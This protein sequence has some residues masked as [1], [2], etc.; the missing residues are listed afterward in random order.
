MKFKIITLL[1]LLSFGFIENLK[2]QTFVHPGLPFTTGD[3]DRM[4]ANRTASPWQESWEL[5]LNSDQASLDYVMQGPTID[6]ENGGNDD[7][8][9]NDVNAI[10]YHALQYYFTKDEAYAEKAIAI[11]KP[12]VRTHKTWSG[13]SAH[14]SAAWRGGTFAQACEILRYTYP[15]WTDELSVE[16]ED[17]LKDVFWPLFRLPDPL[18]SANQGANNLMGAMYVA[19]F[20]NDKEKFDMCIEAFLN[21]SCGGISN[22]LPNG[23]NGD[24]GRDQG[25]AMAMIGNLATV[26]EIAWA[27][28]FDLYSALDNRLLTIHEYWTKYNLGNDVPWIDFGTCYGYYTSIGADGRTAS[29][30][31]PIPVTEMI[32][33][34]YVIRKGLSA[35]YVTE[36]RAGLPVDENTFLYRKDN[37]FLSTNP[38]FSYDSD[39]ELEYSDV[40][41]LTA[42]DIGTVG[43]A[44]SS[45][46][47]NG[48]WTVAGSGLN[49]YGSS[50]NDSFHYAYK[51]MSGDG[52]FIAKITSMEVSNS[53][54]KAALVIKETLDSNSKMGEVNGTS[55]SSSE[56]S[57]R[58]SDSADGSGKQSFEL[59]TVPTWVKIERIGDH[60][61]GYV[62]P[63]GVSWAPMQY[64]KYTMSDDFYIGL[65]VTSNSNSLTCTSTFT[66][67]Q[68][69]ATNTD[70]EIITTAYTK[71]E[72]E[73]YTSMSGITT[74]TT[75]DT[76]GDM[77][78]ST[79]NT[80]DWMEYTIN[81]PYSGTYSMDYRIASASDGNFTVSTTD[82]TLE[83]V[84]FTATGGN[85]S[86]ATVPS[87]S[88]FYLSQGVQ[89]I[90]IATNSSDWKI[91]WLR[92]F[93]ECSDSTIVPYIE[94]FDTSGVSLGKRQTS[95]VTVLPGNNASLSPLDIE[96]GS[97]SWTGPNDF[98]STEREVVFEN[99]EATKAG[100]YT[101]SY[102]NDC[103]QI[104]NETFTINSTSGA[105]F[106]A[107]DYTSM[108]DISTETTSDTSGDSNVTDIN[109]GDWM[110]YQ[111]NVPYRGY[112]SID[113]RVASALNTIDFDLNINDE[114]SNQL[115]FDPTGGAQV[116][117]TK[118]QTTSVYLDEGLQTLRILPTT[119][120]WNMNWVNLNF[121]F[122]VDD[123]VIP[124]TNDGFS[125]QNT[126]VDWTSGIQNISCKDEVDILIKAETTGT[127]ASSD[128]LK[129]YYKLDNGEKVEITNK[130]VNDNKLFFYAQSIKGNTLEV[131][132]ES[133][134]SSTSAYYTVTK[135]TIYDGLDQYDIIQAEHFTTLYDTNSETCT[136]TDGGAN[137]SGA[138]NGSYLMYSNL[139]LSAIDSINLRFATKTTGGNLEI[140]VDS[141]TGELLGTVALSY[142]GNWQKWETFT[143][144]LSNKIGFYD[145]YL[146]FTT[147]ETD[148]VGNLNW[149]ELFYNTDLSTEDF[150]TDT[151][152]ALIIYPNP[153]KDE[154]NILLKQAGEINTVNIYNIQGQHVL[155]TKKATIDVS[156][157]KS[158]VYFIEVNSNL[159]KAIKKIIL[160]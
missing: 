150:D 135:V 141:A 137:M 19:V 73:D 14:L 128:Y 12:W 113:Y 22:T 124:Y 98:T 85:S 27:Q 57:S 51:K 93:V 82:Q 45:T 36:H 133:N 54:G 154:V 38:S 67:V 119:S 10:L 158:G 11:I 48:T 32:Y 118:T 40:T 149:F 103:G 47:D 17:Y 70:D 37:T 33:G 83:Q 112:Y 56:F 101:V 16:C 81:V 42:T 8:Y 130:L 117:D 111:V 86:W 43:L 116:W 20:C 100:E 59:S 76:S 29:S 109:A 155:S 5:I 147:T 52:S 50:S 55:A 4:A 138:S 145:L 131:I 143:G 74:E 94:S 77:Q 96:G 159:G 3:L 99:I 23:E 129:I 108:Q 140:R 49:I 122:S 28:G 6:V 126:T 142:T 63:D 24:S 25:H 95:T 123:C 157:L 71:I 7:I 30:T 89:T 9:I 132:I 53:L 61:T 66:N 31:D 13:T 26:A 44:G 120:D 68:L 104:T 110:E 69:G 15:G 107:E 136:D 146:V 39:P 72:A 105:Y 84:S 79:I 134:S 102:T 114:L 41:D 2:A 148:Y 87:S 80:D 156:M 160:E 18:R 60:I 144:S 152:E 78:V 46:L 62:G 88:S 92:L 58:G 64:T 121:L 90:K 125:I 139:N 91:N 115:S 34:A 127:L 151:E 75:T 97:W 35:P 106:E 21:D 65:G 1:L 153:A